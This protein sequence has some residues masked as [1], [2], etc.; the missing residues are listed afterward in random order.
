MDYIYA[1]LDI[2]NICTGISKLSGQVE[3]YNY[4]TESNFDPITG[5]YTEDKVVFV[6]RMIKI[7][8]A[9]NNYIGLKYNEG[10]WEKV[11]EEI[12]EENINL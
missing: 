2:N 6:S 1:Q 11:I 7:P 8:V 9:S 10:T 12:P 5:I 3:E 4:K